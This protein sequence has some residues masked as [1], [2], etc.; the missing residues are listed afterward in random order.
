M[1]AEILTLIVFIV[2]IIAI[3]SGFSSVLLD[4]LPVFIKSRLKGWFER[5]FKGGKK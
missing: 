4:L 2:V 5:Y 3:I 1:L